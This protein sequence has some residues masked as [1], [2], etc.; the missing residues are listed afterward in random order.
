MKALRCFPGVCVVGVVAMPS[1]VT[2]PPGVVCDVWLSGA[3][4]GPSSVLMQPC[5]DLVREANNACCVV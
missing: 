3:G 1:V 2:L 5:A 4:G